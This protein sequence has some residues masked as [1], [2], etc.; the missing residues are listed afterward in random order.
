MSLDRRKSNAGLA[1]MFLLSIAHSN[2]GVKSEIIDA[3]A[4]IKE[5]DVGDLNDMESD[6][7]DTFLEQQRRKKV[8]VPSLSEMKDPHDWMQQA[9]G[10]VQMVFCV[11]KQR[12]AEKLLKEGTD[13]LASRWKTMLETGGVN[14]QLY[15]TD[16]GKILIVTNTAGHVSKLKDFVLAQEETDWFEIQQNRHYPPG[17]SGPEMDNDARKQREIELGW[18]QPTPPAAAEAG[19][20]RRRKTKTKE[21]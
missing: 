7:P 8:K 19:K 6:V 12:V 21:L 15:G 10:G 4:D 17:R 20:K 18:R 13:Q 9:Q 3:S 5:L 2:A 11:L 14:V 16:P 1:C